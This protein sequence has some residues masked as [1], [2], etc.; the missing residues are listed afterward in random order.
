MEEKAC[1][2]VESKELPIIVATTNP[3]KIKRFEWFI[4]L[5]SWNTKINAKMYTLN[6]LGITDFNCPEIYYDFRSN[7]ALKRDMLFWR[8]NEDPASSF[9][10]DIKM[11]TRDHY[12]ILA[13]DSGVEIPELNYW[14]G[15]K[16]K[17]CGDEY[18]M[19][20]AQMITNRVFS[21]IPDLDDHWG[22]INSA[23][24]AKCVYNDCTDAKKQRRT[25]VLDAQCS[26]NVR[27]VKS[28]TDAGLE[29]AWDICAPFVKLHDGTIYQCNT[30]SGMTIQ[31]SILYGDYMWK[32][33]EAVMNRIAQNNAFIK[34]VQS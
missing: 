34:Q 13:D 15:V 31:T 16:T 25:E 4:K 20:S 10:C 18:N 7:A 29:T 3:T 11:I 24:A 23:I 12:V 22:I 27:F 1:G 8:I 17:R 26:Q 28:P 33:F 19:T 6:D 5:W 9:K 2:I 32:A 14:P 30:Y 21:E